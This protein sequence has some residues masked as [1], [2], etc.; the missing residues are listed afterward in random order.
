L[1]LGGY[2]YP[3]YHLADHHLSIDNLSGYNYVPG[4]NHWCASIRRHLESD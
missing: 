3:G 1:W 2:N 4:Y